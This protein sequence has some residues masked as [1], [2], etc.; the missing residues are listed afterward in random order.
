MTFAL[1][2]CNVVNKTNLSRN[3][4]K[5][6]EIV[7]NKNDAFK[8]YIETLPIEKL[9]YQFIECSTDSLSELEKAGSI[10]KVLNIKTDLLKRLND[11]SDPLFYKID[12]NKIHSETE[13]FLDKYYYF[14]L[15][16]I[17]I[18]TEVIFSE[19]YIYK[20]LQSLNNNIEVILIITQ[21][22]DQKPNFINT[23]GIQIDIL[24]YSTLLH[25][26]INRKRL[27]TTGIGL[28]DIAYHEC[29][30]I[31]TEYNINTKSFMHLE[32]ESTS[33]EIELKIDLDGQIK[34]L[35]NEVRIT[36]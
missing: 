25:K 6:K 18:G 13:S 32:D 7:Y 31:N 16:N 28:E 33:I 20:R 3:S 15:D 19:S 23:K 26:S 27:I 29:F 24:T 12:K 22:I 34:I 14:L 17:D 30:N 9:P 11:F 21:I 10:G 1:S 36:N 8:K 5:S 4:L 35:N 2:C